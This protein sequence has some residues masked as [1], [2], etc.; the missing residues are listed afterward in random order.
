M[1]LLFGKKQRSQYT[2]KMASLCRQTLLPR[3]LHIRYV[4]NCK[5]MRY[6]ELQRCGGLVT[7]VTIFSRQ[8]G[9]QDHA[10]W[11]HR[12]GRR[13]AGPNRAGRSVWEKPRTGGIGRPLFG[14]ERRWRGSKARACAG[15]ACCQ[16]ACWYLSVHHWAVDSVQSRQGLQDVRGDASYLFEAIPTFRPSV[17]SLEHLRRGGGNHVC[18]CRLSA[19]WITASAPLGFLLAGQRARCGFEPGSRN[20][21]GTVSRSLA[22]DCFLWNRSRLSSRCSISAK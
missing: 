11:S 20:C 1:L 2:Q 5:L 14:K 10:L 7:S 12:A 3:L 17:Q 6:S 8:R 18:S 15:S 13:R 21:I 4:A 9:W 16:A 22:E 19:G